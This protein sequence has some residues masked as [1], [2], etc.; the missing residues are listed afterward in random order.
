MSVYSTRR[1]AVDFLALVFLVGASVATAATPSHTGY[2]RLMQGPMVGTVTEQG[3]LIW[4][5]LSGEVVVDGH[6]VRVAVV[7][8]LATGDHREVR[9]LIGELAGDR[10]F[11]NLFAYTGSFSVAAALAG[12]TT[13]TVDVAEDHCFGRV[14]DDGQR[15][16]GRVEEGAA[17]VQ[18][19]LV[20]RAAESGQG[21]SEHQVRVAVSVDVTPRD[22]TG[23]AR[24]C[25][26]GR[27][28][29]SCR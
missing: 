28:W 6:L 9:R 3:A 5:R 4:L 25:W 21:V 10:H 22:R 8:D 26:Q 29:S 1:L 12:A 23:L 11:L 14:Q 24:G 20:L 15:D 16:R 18:K 17:V 27:R 7:V 13:T 19:Q 2:P